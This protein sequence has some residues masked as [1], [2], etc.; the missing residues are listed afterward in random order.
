MTSIARAP[1]N[2][3]D[4]LS[5]QLP[6]FAVISGALCAI[7][8]PWKDLRLCPPNRGNLHYNIRDGIVVANALHMFM[9]RLLQL[10]CNDPYLDGIFRRQKT[11]DQKLDFVIRHS[12]DC[13]PTYVL[14]AL[15]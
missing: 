9:D 12:H 11:P 2:S 3:L 15:R 13:S 10:E 4:A 8:P 6:L 14:P 7:L 1:R 5:A